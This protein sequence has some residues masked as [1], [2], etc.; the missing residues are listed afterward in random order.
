LGLTLILLLF[1]KSLLGFTNDSEKEIPNF[2]L[3]VIIEDRV[4]LFRIDAFKALIYIG[5]TTAVLFLG[6]KQKINQNIALLVIG[7]VSLFDLWSVNR[8][9]LNDDNYV[10]KE[11]A[12]NPFQ[13]ETSDYID[14]T[15]SLAFM[16]ASVKTNKI[17]QTYAKK[18]TMHYRIYNQ[19]LGVT[20]ETNTSYFKSSIGGYHAVR[21]RRYDDIMN[22]YILQRDSVKTRKILNLLNTKYMIF[23]DLE[24]LQVEFNP[25]ANGNAWFV[26]DLR[27]AAN[28]NEEIA[29]VGEID[30]KKT[31]VINV[32]DKKYF[33]GKNLQSDSTATI[34]LT[35]YEPNEL[36][37]KSSSKTPQLAVFSEVYYPHGWKVSVDGKEVDYV[38]ADYLLRAVHVPAGSHNIKMI[39]EP[40]V[41][42]NGKWISLIC[43]ALFILVS[44][45][46]IYFIYRKKEQPANIG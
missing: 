12:E 26:S 40:Q 37:F 43:F 38:K 17:L 1:G 46:G 25:N 8:N 14:E 21:L 22:A 27:F 5:I 36:E 13:V 32:E 11:F 16:K 24:N 7:A 28:S 6:L 31:A 4:K 39:F 10:K 2:I 41:I 20:G 35:K 45:G 3:D 30:N 33:D 18:D 23:G 34:N 44:A 29:L 19:V 15:P 42:E 9:Y